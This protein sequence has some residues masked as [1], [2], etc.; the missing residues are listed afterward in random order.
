[1]GTLT[2]NR[3]RVKSAKLSSEVICQKRVR[4]FHQRFQ[5]PRNRWKHEAAGQVLLLF[6]GVWS[7]WWNTKREFLIWLLKW[8]NWKLCS[9]MFSK[10]N[11]KKLCSVKYFPLSER[12]RLHAWFISVQPRARKERKGVGAKNGLRR[13]ELSQESCIPRQQGIKQLLVN[14]FNESWITRVKK[15]THSFGRLIQIVADLH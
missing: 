2:L 4:L 8:N 13:R 1:M 6:R 3:L 15:N 12:T 7:P 11:N 14:Y 9:D 10:R 5:T